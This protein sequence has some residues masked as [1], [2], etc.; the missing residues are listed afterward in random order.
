MNLW[1]K[2]AASVIVTTRNEEKYI[3]DC[4][5]SVR[6]QTVKNIEII[7]TDSKSTDKTVQIARKYANRVIVKNCGVSEGRNAGAKAAR[8]DIL[9]FLDA[10]TMLMPD[11]LEKV[12]EP[13]KSRKVVGTTCPVLPTRAAPHYVATYMFHNGFSRMSTIV[14]KPQVTAIFCTYRKSSFE[15]VGGFNH[16]VGIL[17]DYHLSLKIGKLGRVRFVESA[18]ALT[19]PRRLQKMGIRVPD[20]MLTA[21]LRLLMTG[22]S[23][24]WKWYDTH[25]AR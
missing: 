17:E 24:S 6:N 10:D 19:S 25:R 11:A 4:L 14:R 22:K 20:R 7:V 15:K 12:L 2:P 1:G 16:E 5:R 23:Y 9:V 13:Y 3:G 8:S 21:W 18:L